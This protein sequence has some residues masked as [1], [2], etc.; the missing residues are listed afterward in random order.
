V[1]VAHGCVVDETGRVV[2]EGRVAADPEAMAAW[3]RQHAP[4][5]VRVGIETG[6][7]ALWHA[8]SLRRL[9]V[10]VV[11]ID[12]RHAQKVLSCWPIKTD[13]NDARGLAELVRLGAIREVAVKS[14]ESVRRRALLGAR[15]QLVRMR[16]D[17]ENQIRGL[18]KSFG[19]LMGAVRGH[20]FAGRARELVEDEPTLAGIV[21]P[22]LRVRERL[23]EE[24]QALETRLVAEAKRDP[25]CRRLATVPGVG[26]IT[27]LAFQSGVDDISRFPDRRQVGAWLGLVPRRYQ[28]GKV[29]YSGKIS[30]AGDTMLRALLFEA[31]HVLMSRVKRAC[32]LKS[33]A[34][35]LA[36]RVGMMKTKVAVARKLAVLLA[37]LWAKEEEFRWQPA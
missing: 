3:L 12:A 7:L 37:R 24:A 28:S 30:R 20:G 17:V 9:G 1:K 6:P 25:V 5:L 16:R 10:P 13:K 32:A 21:E 23:S 35:Q 8:H 36:K 31:A 18:L 33:W 4:G 19:K 14:E 22:L 2:K 26:P 34:E 11:C 15:E 27:A 29:D